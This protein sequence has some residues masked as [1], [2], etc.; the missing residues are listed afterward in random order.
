MVVR[1]FRLQ[2][3]EPKM[4][5]LPA[6]DGVRRL[7]VDYRKANWDFLKHTAKVIVAISD[8]AGNVYTSDKLTMS[9]AFSEYK[10]WTG[11]VHG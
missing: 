7:Y 10:R 3:Q 5:G 4:S 6:G 1:Q 9:N 8:N 2:R 11:N